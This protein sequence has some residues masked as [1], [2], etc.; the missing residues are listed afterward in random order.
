MIMSEKIPLKRKVISLE[1]KILILD[2]LHQGEKNAAI[3]KNLKINEASVR[4][5]KK[6]ESA[7]RKS[8][9]DGSL[10]SIKYSNRLRPSIME[11]M[12]KALNIW[13]ED[14]CQKRIPLSK[15]I[16][17]EKALK[18]YENLKKSGEPSVSAN[19]TASNGWFEHFKKRSAIHSLK[20]QGESA[21]ADVEA[22]NTYP[23]E[24]QKYIDQQGY[25]RDQVFNADET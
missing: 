5:I 13:V 7:I 8:V 11:K 3:A 10:T 24:I 21:S 23:K 1:T 15:Q 9:A 20:V 22:A 18:I 4:T 25:V 2:R 14:N 17:K 6:N 16:I 12:E 19:F